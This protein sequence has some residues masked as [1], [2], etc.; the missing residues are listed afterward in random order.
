VR[1]GCITV[2][3]KDVKSIEPETLLAYFSI[4]FQDVV[5]FNDTLYN[6]IKIGKSNAVREDILAAARA[7]QCDEFIRRFPL[8]Y[9]TIIGENGYTLS[10][11]ERQR[12]SIARALLKN[13]PIILLDEATASLDTENESHVQRAL[14]HLV[15]DKTV[16]VIAHRIRTV[17]EAD[18]IVV[19]QDGRV[20]EEG[21]HKTLMEQD[22]LY[23]KLV[24]LQQRSANWTIGRN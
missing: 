20:L 2:G 3:G 1:D 19:L 5:L 24:T 14:S 10:G 21:T 9:D 11:G 15:M 22:G 7:A 18:K 23:E 17:M 13:A 16:I 6:N 4:V 12:I 8:G